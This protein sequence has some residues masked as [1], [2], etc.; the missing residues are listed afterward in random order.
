MS[1]SIIV[2]LIS[3]NSIYPDLQIQSIDSKSLII[4]RNEHTKIKST[5]C[6][7]QQGSE[8]INPYFSNDNKS[9]NHTPNSLFSNAL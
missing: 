5:R 7:R 2:E 9:D 1:S 6:A 8:S 4:G 3:D